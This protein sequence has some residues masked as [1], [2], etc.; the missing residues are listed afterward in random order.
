ML[1]LAIVS[2][3]I[4]THV[5]FPEISLGG[6]TVPTFHN[7]LI[8]GTFA[9][10]GFVHGIKIFANPVII[11]YTVILLITFTLSSRHP[12][13]ST[14]QPF[15][16][17][18]ALT[19]AILLLHLNLKPEMRFV[20]LRLLV[21]LAPLS[22]LIG[23]I[24]DIANVHTVF[25]QEDASTA[26]YRLQGASIPALLASVAQ[27]GLISAYT[28][29]TKNRIY[30]WLGIL[31][32]AIIAATLT[33]LEIAIGLVI[34]GVF[35]WR[36]LRANWQ[37]ISRQN[38]RFVLLA[39]GSVGIIILI[40]LPGIFSRSTYVQPEHTIFYLVDEAGEGWTRAA[41]KREVDDECPLRQDGQVRVNCLRRHA[42]DKGSKAVSMV[43]I[44]QFHDFDFSGQ[45]NR[46]FEN[47]NLP[48]YTSGRLDAWKRYWEAAQENLVWGRGLGASTVVNQGITTAF[49]VPHNEYLRLVVDS[50]FVGLTLMLGAYAYLLYRS[51]KAQHTPYDK[52][53]M[54]LAI[55]AFVVL[56][57]FDN[58]LSAQA[59]GIPFWFYAAIQTK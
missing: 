1:L 13:L 7:A 40:A 8:L 42:V 58:P 12:N 34:T 3:G 21:V 31:N 18:F 16:S 55:G 27:F 20:G 48:I 39:I 46:R 23:I 32:F 4:A 33:R 44:I 14:I 56:A 25:R 28:L 45:E 29:A 41:R 15:K 47:E 50:G 37:Q 51:Y 54:M 26:V 59:I 24:L 22:I 17:Y 36:M 6:L 38:R 19:L 53:M 11:G 52:L 2:L 30:A 57:G 43:H 10:Y 35:F 49:V 9:L 5:I